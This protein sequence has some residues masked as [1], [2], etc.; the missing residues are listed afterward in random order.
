MT[1]P[2][3][4][5]RIFI[6]SPGDVHEERDKA[7]RVI[8]ALQRYYTGVTLQPVLWEDLALPATA[9]F[10][11]TI[12]FILQKEP[13]EIAVFI[14]WS[15]LGSLL[16]PAI[17]RADG[18]PYRS[19]TER[20][21]DVM[22]EAF[23]QSGQRRPI[24]LAYTRTDESGFR[25]S[26]TSCPAS[27]LEELISQRKLAESF[28]RE[29]FKDAEGH[30]VRAYHSYREPVSF[31]QRLHTHLHQIIDELLGEEVAPRWLDEPY[32][33]LEVF[34][35]E[36]APIFQG[37]DE[38]TCDILQRLRDQEQSGCAFAVIVG[39]SG[40]GKSS[41]ARAGVAA[42]LTQHAYDHQVKAWRIVTLFPSLASGDLNRSLVRALAD[43]LPELRSS[44][45]ALDDIASGLAKDATLTVKLSII[46]AFTRAAEA[47]RGQV[48]ILLLVD[49]LEE[50]W[51]DRRITE[52]DREQFLGVLEALA[53]SR[54]MAVLATLRSDFYPHAQRIPAFLRLKGD[55]GHCDLLPPG[56]AALYRLITEPAR[57]AG[58]RFEQLAQTGRT[59]DQ[60]ILQDASRHPAAL[61]LLQ[62]ALSELYQQRDETN[63]QLT[64]AAYQRIGGVEGAL[65]KRAADIFHSLAPEVGAALPEILPQLVTIDIDGEQSAVRRR[66]PLS[67]LTDT[68]AKKALTE[69][70]IAARFLTTDRQDDTPIVSLAH[71]ALL[72]RWDE[73][74]QWV[75]NNREHLRLRARAEQSQQRW[76]QQKDD[77][78]LFLPSGLPLEEGQILIR[79]ARL[80]LTP[81]TV[82]YIER[83]IEYRET[84]SR[85]QRLVRNTALTASLAA[86]LI[87]IVAAFWINSERSAAIVARNTAKTEAANAK[88]QEGK[89]KEQEAIAKEQAAKARE[90]EGIA[91]EAKAKAVASAELLSTQKK[92]LEAANTRSTALLAEAAQSDR[93]TARNLWNLGRHQDALAHLARSLDYVSRT[94]AEFPTILS[95]SESQYWHSSLASLAGHLGDVNSAEFSPDGSLIVTGSNDNTARIWDATT[96]QSLVTLVG[97]EQFVSSATFSPDGSRIV[98]ASWDHTA[99]VWNAATG[100]PLATLTGHT[101]VV[102]GAVFSPD[103]SRIVTASWDN[104]ARVWDTTTGQP[105]VILTGHEDQL[106]RA[107]FSPDGSRI[108]TASLDETARMWD[109][110]SGH[111]LFTFTGHEDR[112]I[113]AAFSPDCSQVVTSSWDR[114]ARLWDTETGSLIT[115]LVGH[116]DYVQCATFSPDGTRIVTASDDNTARLWD[117][118]TGKLLATLA[119]HKKAVTSAVFSPDGTRIVTASDDNTA[120]L[121]DTATGQSLATLVGHEYAVKSASFSPDGS[122]IVTSPDVQT[123]QVWDAATGQ[124]LTI[125]AGHD[126]P[127]EYAAFSPDGSRIVTASWDKTARLWDATTGQ[128]YVTL[129][130]HEYA[131]MSACFRPDGSRIV[132]ASLDNSARLWDAVSGQ[133]LAILVG[134]EDT[135]MSAEFSP[136][137]TRIVTASGDSTARLWDAAD[138]KS[139]STLVGHRK[140]LGSAAFSPDGSRVVT[141]SQ[142][143]TTRLWDAASGQ[144]TATFA[145]HDLRKV[146]AAY[147][148]DGSLI[149]TPSW[150][151]TA[152]LWDSTSGIFLATLAGHQD[153][154][155]SAVFSPDG[156]RIVTASGDNTAR[157]WDVATRNSIAILAGHEDTV[158]SAAFSH[159]GTRI[160]T[161]SDDNTVRVWDLIGDTTPPPTWFSTCLRYLGH[162]SHNIR[163]ELADWPSYTDDLQERSRLHRAV[164][165]D[166]TRFGDIGRYLL[167]P[168]PAKPTHPGSKVTCGE[169]ADRLIR[170]SA[171][172]SDI[173]RASCWHP[174]HPL[175]QIAL[176]K[177]EENTTRAEFLR[178]YGVSRLLK[179]PSSEQEPAAKIAEL[180]RRA[181]ALL[182]DQK[183]QLRAD[184]V[185]QRA[186]ELEGL[187]K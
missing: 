62:Y 32:R 22:L 33:G 75:T 24:I 61:P 20:E 18:S 69:A 59:L 36:H 96:G 8:D 99:R 37:R 106:T 82:R 53:R 113:C 105:L 81:E 151:N 186:E 133:S 49:Q 57:L 84:E 92:D 164:S 138:G 68:P 77:P 187:K 181:E 3:K 80:L 11:E 41:L 184:R 2:A 119:G 17:T 152:K 45:T 101:S 43:Q 9:S 174:G 108:I 91:N 5:L 103:G 166:Q 4:T 94:A 29:Q 176:A 28:I 142:D 159:D 65:G 128:L 137:G 145:G 118:V 169:G 132:T 13:I 110:K 55:R 1:S 131:V 70:L 98:T 63:H 85:R 56:P 126:G 179:R 66:A 44:P 47:A 72:R 38:E 154:V 73:L 23:A 50:L 183:D 165:A 52:T 120:Q 161:A 46:P 74:S 148:P 112:V 124:L 89:A 10:Q 180:C 153:H 173:V 144:S 129:L 127:V 162:R 67:S 172:K 130:G 178:E 149:V 25:Q 6:S 97:H 16:G 104:T 157:L 12:D 136:D 76:L 48:R 88:T 86:A 60:Q 155:T 116:E 114:T 102:M 167:T 27:S 177:F 123:P 71:E 125:F 34:D 121:W 141:A 7:R 171:P 185:H 83:S 51:T 54:Q 115:T 139:L 170:P 26:L 111:S 168:H 175:L 58:L 160:V 90:Q 156:T 35:V 100:Q 147:N 122:R 134:H 79:D 30:N 93:A 107:G 182:L 143:G 117:A 31:A 39:A 87:A 64:F 163:G 42:A 140:A 135:V 150:F 78:S 15:R 158:N 40:S 109:A 19:G 14:L 21:F 95:I 146:S